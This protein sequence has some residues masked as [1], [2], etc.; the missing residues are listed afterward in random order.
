MN[1]S[2]FDDRDVSVLDGGRKTQGPPSCSRQRVKDEVESSLAQPAERKRIGQGVRPSQLRR[3]ESRLE[4]DYRKRVAA[5]RLVAVDRDAIGNVVVAEQCGGVVIGQLANDDLARPRPNK[6][7]V[8]L[9]ARTYDERKGQLLQDCAGEHVFH[10][11]ERRLVE[12]LQVV[13]ANDNVPA[14]RRCR[15]TLHK[16][17]GQSPLVEV[18]KPLARPTEEHRFQRPQRAEP[19]VLAALHPSGKQRDLTRA[20]TA[21]ERLIE[22]A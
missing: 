14:R 3:R 21:N 18:L 16:S 22:Q 8:M 13:D 6:R 11:C 9:R 19:L 12:C 1:E 20:V 15:Q 17:R 5:E 4:F 10:H 2:K 7:D